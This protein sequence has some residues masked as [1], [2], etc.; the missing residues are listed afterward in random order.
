MFLP[1]TRVFLHLNPGVLSSIPF[2]KDG[3]Q[4]NTSSMQITWLLLILSLELFL[5]LSSNPN[6]LTFL[7]WLYFLLIQCSVIWIVGWRLIFGPLLR[8][9]SCFSYCK[10]LNGFNFPCCPMRQGIML[11]LNIKKLHQT[12]SV[13]LHSQSRRWERLANKSLISGLILEFLMF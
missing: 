8:A 12:F 5:P 3:Q 11:A 6:A 2:P 13:N 10:C 7:Y 9:W 1:K 4:S